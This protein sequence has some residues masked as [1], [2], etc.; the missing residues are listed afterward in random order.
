VSPRKLA[1]FRVEEELLDALRR[2]KERDGIPISEQCRRALLVW[3]AEKGETV[4]KAE[5]KRGATRKRS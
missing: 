5:R 3:I 1:N 4:K 2:I